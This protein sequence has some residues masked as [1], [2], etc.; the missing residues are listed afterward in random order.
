MSSLKSDLHNED[1]LVFLKTLSDNS[2][3]MVLTDPPYFKIMKNNWDRQWK[4]EEEYLNWCKEWTKECIRVLKPGGCLY[5]WGTTKTDTFLRYKLQVLNSFS[6]LVYQNWIIWHYDWGGRTKK[7]FARKH[8]DLLMYSKG[9]TFPFYTN[10]IRIPYKMK[11]NPRKGVTNN[12]LGKIPTDV[13][14]KNNHT[15]SK[16]FCS[17]HPTQK[18]VVLL[19]RIIRAGT[20]PGNTVLDIFA[21]SGST[22]VACDSTKRQFLGCEKDKDYYEKS[23]MRRKRMSE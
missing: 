21:G 15:T 17:W 9:K 13:W 20:K 16:E 19:E 6:D 4:T 14:E 18:P 8:E 12:P 5:V 1:C 11:N 2:V 10:E 3:D 22:A 7:T 23:L